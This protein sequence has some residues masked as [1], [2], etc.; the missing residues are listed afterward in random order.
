MRV[1]AD[2]ERR[3]YLSA[4]LKIK[5]LCTRR[6]RHSEQRNDE[7]LVSPN[8]QSGREKK[9]NKNERATADLVIEIPPLTKEVAESRTW[10]VSTLRDKVLIT[11]DYISPH[12]KIC[13]QWKFECGI[14]G[15]K[16]LLNILTRSIENEVF[17]FAEM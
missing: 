13:K 1:N 10:A 8:R 2:T 7:A 14:E 15:E 16:R 3:I 4:M 9:S 17:T 11:M 12:A 5:A 6:N